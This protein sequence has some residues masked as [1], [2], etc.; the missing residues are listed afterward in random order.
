MVFCPSADVVAGEMWLSHSLLSNFSTATYVIVTSGPA[1]HS[2]FLSIC[3]SQA[4][5]CT[6][7]FTVKLMFVILFLQFS[8]ELKD[9]RICITGKAMTEFAWNGRAQ[10]GWFVLPLFPLN[11]TVKHGT[12]DDT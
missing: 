2:D 5:C 1:S 6:P 7:S 3:E 12:K 11:E 4:G 10:Y 8:D 9:S